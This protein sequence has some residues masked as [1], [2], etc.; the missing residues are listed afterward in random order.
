MAFIQKKQNT[1]SITEQKSVKSISS[2]SMNQKQKRT[3]AKQQQVSESLAKIAGEILSKT[4]EGVSAIEELKSAMEQI[5]AASEQNAGA[6]EQSLSAVNQITRTTEVT[7]EQSKNAIITTNNVLN[8][9]KQASTKVT[10]TASRLE[11][12]LKTSKDLV[13]KSNDLKVASENI[14]ESVGIIAKVADQTNLLALNA[15]IEAARAKEHGKGFAVVA[16]ETRGLAAISAQNADATRDVVANIQDAIEKAEANIQ[17]VGVIIQ[18]SSSLAENS[19]KDGVDVV[20]EGADATV[21]L[22]SL[23]QIFLKLTDEVEEMQKGSETIASAAEE[24]ASAVNQATSAID[25]Q[26]SALAESEQAATNLDNLAYELK[27]STDVG[28]D[29][30]EI[31]SM[32]EELGSA[33]EEILRSMGEVTGALEQIEKA[34]GL[35]NE[36]A[37]R[38]A[39][40]GTNSLK[41]IEEANSIIGNIQER[42]EDITKRISTISLSLENLASQTGESVELG[43]VTSEEMTKVEKDVKSVSKILRIIENTIIQTTMLAV[44]GSIE[45][46]RAGEFGKGF[47]V[48]S[49]DIRNLAQEAGV[50]LEKIN[51]ILEVLDVETNYIVREWG[52]SVDTQ[53]KEKFQVAALAT[54]LKLLLKDMEDVIGTLSEMQKA[55]EE[56]VTALNQALQGSEQIQQAANQAQSNAGESK[57]AANL[58]E[59]TV[60]DMGNLVEELAVLADE[61]Q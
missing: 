47:A 25:M 32:A 55:N 59:S 52:L 6:A 44:S 1:T 40:V 57:T 11:D 61:L 22:E 54:Q 28:K 18:K 50:N 51:E 30:E 20:S 12:G 46:A 8:E 10:G 7:I 15:A 37:S 3:L 34:A 45:A 60:E 14:G 29:S 16:G 13:E 23:T 27:N 41:M 35:A 42:A 43:K 9:V 58:I 2:G 24:Q 39:E 56:N 33:V 49:S 26:A 48:V 17:E 31:A 21:A 53:D 36:D 19:A 38:N 5:A 4:Q